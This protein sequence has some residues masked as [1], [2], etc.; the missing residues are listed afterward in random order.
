MYKATYLV[1]IGAS[2]WYLSMPKSQENSFKIL[3]WMF[4]FH[5][6]Y[7]HFLI[8]ILWT[9]MVRWENLYSCQLLL[10]MFLISAI[11]KVSFPFHF[12]PIN[13][14]IFINLLFSC[15]I[16]FIWCHLFNCHFCLSVSVF[17]SWW[18]SYKLELCDVYNWQCT[19]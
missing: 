18:E 19:L 16:N 13:F 17:H 3:S 4:S 12:L 5:I 2:Y 11:K 1:F 14:S 10:H 6:D 9:L 8:I 7:S 15:K